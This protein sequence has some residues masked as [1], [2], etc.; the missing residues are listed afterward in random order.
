MLGDCELATPRIVAAIASGAAKRTSCRVVIR[1]SPWVTGKK[2]VL[3]STQ[4]SWCSTVASVVHEPLLLNRNR[5]VSAC[6]GSSAAIGTMCW[7]KK[8]RT[9]CRR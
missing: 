3:N 7:F 6:E 8:I 9:E 4:A 5:V 1:R 2:S